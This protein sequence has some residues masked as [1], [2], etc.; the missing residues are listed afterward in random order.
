MLWILSLT[1]SGWAQNSK[2]NKPASPLRTQVRLFWHNAA[3]NEVVWGDLG[4]GD[5]WVL[6]WQSIEGFPKLAESDAHVV[7]LAPQGDWVVAAVR[8]DHDGAKLSGWLAINHGVTDEAHGDHFHSKYADKPRLTK[9]NL[10]AE[11]GNP[12]HLDTFDGSL[13]LA[14]DLKNGFTMFSSSSSNKNAPVDRFLEGGGGHISLAAVAGAVCYATWVDADGEN[15]GRVDVVSLQATPNP[16]RYSFKLPSPSIHG[17]TA[18]NRRIY[19]AA[20]DGI[21]WVDADTSLSQNPQKITPQHVSLGKDSQDKPLRTGA[22]VNHGTNVLFVAGKGPEAFLGSL[23]A[24]SAKPSVRKLGIPLQEGQSLTTP[25]TVTLGNGKQYAG[26][27]VEN[28]ATAANEELLLIDLDPNQD[29]DC[30]DAKIAARVPIG[31][32]KIEGHSGHHDVCFV[33]SK[34]LAIV[35]NPGDESIQVVSLMELKSLATL[36]VGGQPMQISAVGGK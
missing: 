34:R 27:F 18:N 5:T 20:T 17:A 1:A 25:K 35:T 16:K 29:R 19:L 30:A 8:D 6:T 23:S 10:N 9:S 2:T 21:Y 7:Q 32:S 26:L 4:K 11:Q 36:K 15:A 28:R 31:K 13:F 24:A 14:N 12:A 22:F 33:A 3:T